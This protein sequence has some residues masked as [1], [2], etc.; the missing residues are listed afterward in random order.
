MTISPMMIQ[1]K[2][3]RPKRVHMKSESQSEDQ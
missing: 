1:S 3:K 2:K